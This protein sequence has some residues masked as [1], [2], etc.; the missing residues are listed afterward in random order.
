[1]LRKCAICGK[2][3]LTGKSVVRK[4]MAKSKGGTGKK[5]VRSAKRKFFP[6]LQK[7][8]ILINNRPKRAYVCAKCIKKGRIKKV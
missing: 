1:M 7:V 5:I 3:P 4:G 6:N 8:R 2:G